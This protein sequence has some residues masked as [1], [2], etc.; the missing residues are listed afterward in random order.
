MYFGDGKP[1]GWAL[2]TVLLLAESTLLHQA[3]S[4][5]LL[6]QSAVLQLNITPTASSR[7]ITMSIYF[8]LCEDSSL[9]DGLPSLRELDCQSIIQSR[10]RTRSENI[11]MEA[12]RLSH[13]ASFLW[14]SR[15]R[16]CR[17]MRELSV[18]SLA[19]HRRMWRCSSF[20]E[21][22]GTSVRVSWQF[23]PDNCL[24]AHG[25]WRRWQTQTYDSS[26]LSSSW[27]WTMETRCWPF[28]HCISDL[29]TTR[30]GPCFT[31]LHAPLQNNGIKHI[32][33]ITTLTSSASVSFILTKT[34]G[35]MRTSKLYGAGFRTAV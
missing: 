35:L 34:L 9:Q 1:I 6:I 20:A 16:R 4:G 17:W 3:S 2:I 15:G 18:L 26:A 30:Y 31:P 11:R 14:S 22:D 10:M 23:A 13:P 19:L 7:S 28:E 24:D 27:Q 25:T 12:S 8:G 29:C 5:Q 32:P 21:E 33:K